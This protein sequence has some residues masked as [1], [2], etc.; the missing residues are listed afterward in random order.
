MKHR[1]EL[2]ISH[3]LTADE[4]WRKINQGSDWHTLMI[5]DEDQKVCSTLTDGDIRRGLLNGRTLQDPVQ[6]FCPPS[7][8]SLPAART[9]A[10]S[11]LGE[12]AKGILLIPVLNEHG[13]YVGHYDTTETR[14]VLP[15]EA[16]ILAG[17]KGLRMQPLSLHTPK[18]LLPIQGKPLLGR[19]IDHLLA[20][21]VETIHFALHHEA[22]RVAEFVTEW[23]GSRA[24]IQFIREAQ[25]LGTAGALGLLKPTRPWVWVLNADLMTDLDLE[26]MFLFNQ[27]QGTPACMG[28]STWKTEVP[29]AVLTLDSKGHLSTIQEKPVVHFP[30]N[31][32]IY[33]LNRDLLAAIPGNQKMD[34]PYLISQWLKEEKKI[35][36]FDWEGAWQDI[37]RPDDYFAAQQQ[38]GE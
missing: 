31:A 23:T 10:I 13:Q 2:C 9:H 27:E 14:C 1:P 3:T 5:L 34:M 32:G 33:L 11:F 6:L 26:A 4:A 28:A 15:A 22:D 38:A 12:V 17:G 30:V 19:L 18:P 37:G 16:L 24:N 35:S 25:P 8:V 7:F 29:Y 20:Y 21:G 36:V